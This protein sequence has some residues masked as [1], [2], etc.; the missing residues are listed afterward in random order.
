MMY[1]R[2]AEF[3]AIVEEVTGRL[4][5]F[6]Q[7]ESDVFVITSSGTGGM[8]AAVVNTISP[9]DKVLAV[10]AGKFGDRFAEIAETH[11]A[12][13]IRLNFPWGQA[14]DP[15]VIADALRTDPDV[16]AV[17]VTHNETST[18]VTHDLEAI[19]RVVST[20][21][22]LLLVDAVSSLGAL[23]L[24]VDAWGC[25]VVVTGSQKSWMVP[26]GLAMVSVSP[27]AWDAVARAQAPRFYFDFTAMRR[28]ATRHFT[29]FTPAVSLFYGLQEALRLMWAEGRDNIIARHARVGAHTRAGVKALGLEILPDEAY[30][31]NTVTAVRVP[32]GIT[33]QRLRQ[34]MAEE[35]DVILAG[36]QDHLADLI[37]RIGHLGA[38][39]EAD[40]DDALEAMAKALRK[41]QK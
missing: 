41:L 13:V 32:E 20:T 10:S 6:F 29:P 19:A 35:Y 38:V 11:K 16:R 27:G 31:S 22:A 7:T 36:G 18:G 37:V 17:L 9:G 40:I 23:D 3:A 5:H 1:H 30:A 33:P 25:D 8:E 21:D 4:K 14:A 26:P 34:V 15:G 12:Q 28:S 24:P 2:G 39:V